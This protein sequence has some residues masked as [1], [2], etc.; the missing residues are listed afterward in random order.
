[1]HIVAIIGAIILGLI[2][3]PFLNKKHIQETGV[4]MPTRKQMAY[5]RQKAR[6]LG[7]SEQAAYELWLKN[8]QK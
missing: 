1:M 8:K 4:P 5:I 6:K 3:F 2:V 7:I